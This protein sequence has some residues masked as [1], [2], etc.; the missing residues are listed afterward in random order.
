MRN[1]R[2][3][4]ETV[5]IHNVTDVVPVA[6]FPRL[7]PSWPPAAGL[8]MT[9]CPARA[10]LSLNAHASATTQPTNIHPTKKLRAKMPPLLGCFRTKA[11]MVGVQYRTHGTTWSAVASCY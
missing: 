10:V 7:R 3:T 8:T 11:T 1:P 2:R 5:S 9:V 4:V 6:A